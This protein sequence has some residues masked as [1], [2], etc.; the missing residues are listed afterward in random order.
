MSGDIIRMSLH[1]QVI[2]KEG[3][4][5]Y[6]VLKAPERAS[7]SPA[8]HNAPTFYIE[9]RS[10]CGVG[11]LV[12]QMVAHNDDYMS[13]HSL[14]RQKTLELIEFLQR[15]LPDGRDHDGKLDEG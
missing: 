3:N 15:N 2:G 4:K 1:S 5:E 12:P 10:C 8:K 6:F 13:G 9:S 11:C 7:D 14:N